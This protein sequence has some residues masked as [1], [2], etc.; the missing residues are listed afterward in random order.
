MRK[1]FAKCAFVIFVGA[2][3]NAQAGD[4]VSISSGNPT[5]ED[6]I[7]GFLGEPQTGGDGVKYRGIR[8]I[9]RSKPTGCHVNN[10]AVALKIQFAFDSA[11]LEDVGQG[12]VE[13]VAKAMNSDVLSK[14]KFLIEGHTDSVGGESYNQQLSERR[15]F[16]VLQVLQKTGV[17]ASRLQAIGLGESTPLNSTNLASAE[18]RRVQFKVINP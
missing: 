3:L 5:S 6:I 4:V 12:T 18:N 7:Q 17:S 9:D 10:Q 16:S 11:E 14:C 13:Q 1:V 2:G 15:A 8:M